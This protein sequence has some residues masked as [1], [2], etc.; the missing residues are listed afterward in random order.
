MIGMLVHVE[1][2]RGQ[3]R[4]RRRVISTHWLKSRLSIMIAFQEPDNC[5]VN[6]GIE[7][8]VI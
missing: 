8:R 3:R 2:K 1:N 7:Y 5:G 6:A 4:Q